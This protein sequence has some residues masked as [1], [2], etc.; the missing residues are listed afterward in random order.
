MSARKPLEPA[1][2][3]GCWSDYHS[4]AAHV[5]TVNAQGEL[6][7]P[8]P[9]RISMRDE[10]VKERQLDGPWVGVPATNGRLAVYRIVDSCESGNWHLEFERAMRANPSDEASNPGERA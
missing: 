7:E 9:A 5:D 8:F 4:R 6:T 2:I 3:G 10:G 1:Q